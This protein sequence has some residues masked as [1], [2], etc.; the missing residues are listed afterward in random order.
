MR[1]SVTHFNKYYGTIRLNLKAYYS[2][3]SYEYVVYDNC[4]DI[5]TFAHSEDAEDYGES[6]SIHTNKNFGE[7]MRDLERSVL[8]LPDILILRIDNNI[9]EKILE[10]QKSI[11]VLEEEQNKLE[12]QLNEIDNKIEELNNEIEKLRTKLF[13]IT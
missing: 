13:R 8:K 7:I 1:N 3:D 5:G 2:T 10:K 9:N 6:P 4:K 11:N 12:N